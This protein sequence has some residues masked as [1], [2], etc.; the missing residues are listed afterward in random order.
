MSRSRRGNT[1]I[2]FT[3]V[4]IPLLFTLVSIFE[5]S[6]GMWNF[7]TLQYAVK[8]AARYAAVHGEN[9]STAPNSCAITV[10]DVAA[11]VRQNGI[12][13]DPNQLTLTLTSVSS[14]SS[15]LLSA[16]LA[17][18]SPWPVAPDN[19][20]GLVL[21]IGAR[22]PF[23]SAIAMFWPGVSGGVQFQAVNLSAAA[24]ERIEF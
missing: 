10:A 21:E 23:R 5:V 14:S 18:S 15:C 9:C 20:P 8:E 17:D 4:G 11:R 7:H 22:Y 2:E 13:L 16:C 19:R 3:L 24:Q 1:T 12:G 6:R